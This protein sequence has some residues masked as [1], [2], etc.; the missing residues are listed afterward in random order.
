MNS[1]ILFDTIRLHSEK[2]TI[3]HSIPKAFLQSVNFEKRAG[4]CLEEMVYELHR[5]VYYAKAKDTL[6]TPAS[7]WDHVKFEI[8]KHPRCPEWLRRRLTVEWN[9][10]RA[11]GY[12]P[13]LVPN[14]RTCE[15]EM[16]IC[17]WEEA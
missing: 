17:S 9:T 8:S 3:S 16:M 10:W 5:Y 4:R 2:F 13:E 14:P 12:L 6:R 7:A 11:R 15:A 1:R